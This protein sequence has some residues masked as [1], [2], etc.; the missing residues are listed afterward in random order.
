MTT[1]L[2]FVVVVLGLVALC[3]M[4]LFDCLVKWEYEHHRDQWERDGK[5]VGFLRWH[6]KEDRIGSGSGTAQQLN[7]LWLFKT[8]S[9]ALG[10]P[11]CRRWLIYKRVTTLAA[12][13][14]ILVLLLKLR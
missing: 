1:I 9:W 13:L 8:P 11:Q 5:P 7:I 2:I 14:A 6:P 10:S 12:T 4:W 3:N